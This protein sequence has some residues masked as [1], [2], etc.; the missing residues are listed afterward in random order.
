[1]VEKKQP[2]RV[3]QKKKRIKTYYDVKQPKQVKV[4]SVKGTGVCWCVHHS[5]MVRTLSL[6][7]G[8]YWGGFWALEDLAFEKSECMSLSMAIL[9]S[10]FRRTFF[11]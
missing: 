7:N 3:N 4:K 11:V 9:G 10:R 8:R 1:M 5:R 6:L 2:K